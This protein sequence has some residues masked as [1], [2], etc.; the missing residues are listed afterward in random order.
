VRVL[1]LD[2][3]RL[4]GRATIGFFF[5]LSFSSCANSS[6]GSILSLL[7]RCCSR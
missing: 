7:R 3:D 2:L 4:R 5:S 6:S 1:V